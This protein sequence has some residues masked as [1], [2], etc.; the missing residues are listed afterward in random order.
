MEYPPPMLI[1][2]F[3]MVSYF[4]VTAGVAYD[5]INEPPAIGGFQDPVTGLVKP[6]AI[7]PYRINGQYIMEGA[8]GGLFYT[9]GG[10]GVVLLAMATERNRSRLTRG[11]CRYV[12]ML[13]A[14]VSYLVVMMFIRIKMPGYLS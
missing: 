9:L 12:G 8:C 2:A 14:A 10:T 6:Q 13:L 1:F 4:I 7:M 3:V 11:A 5:V